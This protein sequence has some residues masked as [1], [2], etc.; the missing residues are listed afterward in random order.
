MPPNS[1]VGQATVKTGALK[2]PPAIA[3]A[4]RPYALR[5]TMVKNGTVRLAPT[6]NMRQQCRT[7][8]VFSISGPT[9][10]PG[11]SHRNRIG[12]SNAS[13]SCM[14]R[15]ALSAPSLVIAPARC[16]GLLATMPIGRPSMR[17]S[18][19]TMPWPEVAAQLEHRLPVSASVSIT[20]RT[21]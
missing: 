12:R 21:S 17:A 1:P 20:R 7:S 3:C 19:V 18:A 15:A 8:A 6:T 13:Q 5:S 10:M 11:V 14:K 9:M 2:L 4:P 16:V